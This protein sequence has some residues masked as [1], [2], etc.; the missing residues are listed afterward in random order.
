MHCRHHTSA[1]SGLPPQCAR[2][3]PRQGFQNQQGRTTRQGRLQQEQ[4]AIRRCLR[5][6]ARSSSSSSRRRKL[7][8]LRCLQSPQHEQK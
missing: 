8:T 1:T 2:L 3:P 7:S 4:Q 5:R 6:H